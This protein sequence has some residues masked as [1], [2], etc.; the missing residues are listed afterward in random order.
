MRKIRGDK[1]LGIIIYIYIFIY[2]IYINLYL[3]YIIT[4]II[5]IYI[6]GNI[7]RKLPANKQNV[8]FFFF[9]FLFYKIGKQ[10]GGTGPAQ[11]GGI[12]GREEL[13]GKGLGG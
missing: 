9:S 13:W 1:P 10:E 4:Y 8:M 7:I 5:T 11:G 3:L 12:S 6:Y 2:I